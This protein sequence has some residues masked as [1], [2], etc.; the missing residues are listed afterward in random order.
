MSSSVAKGIKSFLDY[1]LGQGQSIAQQL[2]YAPL[3]S[4]VKSKAQ[5]AV[6]GLECNGKPIG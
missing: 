1:G 2:Q 3:P 4:N 5:Q 6:S